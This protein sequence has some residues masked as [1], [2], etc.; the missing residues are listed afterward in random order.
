MLK[1][2]LE[3]LAKANA[4]QTLVCGCSNVAEKD[5]ARV[6]QQGA[7]S[8]SDVQKTT[9]AGTQCGYCNERARRATQRHLDN[10]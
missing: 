9:K 8:Y 7:A 10:K 3:K 4:G 1:S 6:V 5:I 2:F